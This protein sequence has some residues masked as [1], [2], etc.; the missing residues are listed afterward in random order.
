MIER[1]A[2][3]RPVGPPPEWWRASLAWRE[4][5]A[6]REFETRVRRAYQSAGRSRRRTVTAPPSPTASPAMAH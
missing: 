1:D 2:R 6:Q 5:M 4:E 3:G